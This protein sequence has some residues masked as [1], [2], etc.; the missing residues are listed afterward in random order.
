MHPTAR[1]YLIWV[2]LE[3]GILIG[4][5]VALLLDL[6]HIAIT[7]NIPLHYRC[8]CLFV[9]AVVVAQILIQESAQFP[10]PVAQV[11]Q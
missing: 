11:G 6:M 9:R 1:L 7:L 8:H 5:V 4:I 2:V 10:N 3:A